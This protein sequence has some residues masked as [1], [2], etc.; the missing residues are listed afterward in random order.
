[1]QAEFAAN[2]GVTPSTLP[3]FESGD[4][5]PGQVIDKLIRLYYLAF[6]AEGLLFAD[7]AR[8]S[9]AAAGGVEGRDAGDVEEVAPAGAAVDAAFAA[10][11]VLPGAVGDLSSG[12]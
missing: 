10:G 1:M 4:Q 2:L 9:G 7:G 12:Y 8:M 5:K 6:A 3:R 11:E